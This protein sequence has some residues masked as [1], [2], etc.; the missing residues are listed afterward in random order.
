MAILAL[1]SYN[2]SAQIAYS[3]RLYVAVA[4]LGPISINRAFVIL[5]DELSTQHATR[6]ERK[7]VPRFWRIV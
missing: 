4:T 5:W 1:W 2:S 6:K 7:H 3:L